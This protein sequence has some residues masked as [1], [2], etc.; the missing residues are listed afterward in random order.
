MSAACSVDVSEK[1]VRRVAIGSDSN[2]T[3]ALIQLQNPIQMKSCSKCTRG[4]AYSID[5][6]NAQQVV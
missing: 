1:I 2:Y 4:E 6:I 5:A 3:R